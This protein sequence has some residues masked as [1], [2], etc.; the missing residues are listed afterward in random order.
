MIRQGIG[1]I[2]ASGRV[3][4][5]CLRCL[6]ESGRYAV[7]AG[8]RKGPQDQASLYG[9]DFRPVD[10]FDENQLDAF[11][12]DMGLIINC[13]GPAALIRD[14]AAKAALRH[15]CHFVDA[16]GY[17]PL[18]GAL[19]AA[20][21]VGRSLRFLLAF[22]IMPGLSEIFPPYVAESEFD[23]V[24]A[25][26]YAVIGRDAWTPSSAYDIAWGV[27]NMGREEGA[28]YYRNGCRRETGILGSATR[29]RLPLPV[30]E[31]VLF[32]LMR[33][34]M[35]EFV[36]KCPVPDADVFCNN[37][38]IWVSLATVAV[39]LAGL[40]KTEKQLERAARLIAAASKL[41]MRRK[42]PGFML[43]LRMRG[44]REGR[45]RSLL[46]T[47]Y[48]TD[49][50]RATGICAAIGAHLILEEGIAPG[51]YR[52]ASLPAPT[53]FMRHFLARGYQVACGDGT[54]APGSSSHLNEASAP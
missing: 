30:G 44:S 3:G 22:G 36:E 23:K 46:R 47:L 48:F 27:G 12:R 35:R 34:D 20:A 40:Y 16:G 1:V 33:E 37:W 51:L 7:L 6:S 2:G 5:E 18:Y 21:I 26:S 52:G 41:D 29:M 38:G 32:R 4:Q 31:Q 45:E 10:V 14:R 54:F 17:T 43:H 39:R 25:M 11:C 49:T 28:F 53:V 8:G 9:A 15:G 24:D 50:Y 19:D 42:E 13:A